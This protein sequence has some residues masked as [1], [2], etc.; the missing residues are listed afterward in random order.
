MTQMR[1]GGGDHYCHAEDGRLR[2]GSPEA[3]AFLLR[4]FILRI[5]REPKR[6]TETA[7]GM[8]SSPLRLCASVVKRSAESQ[9]QSVVKKFR[10]NRY[11]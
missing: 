4:A 1:M 3:G 10:E 2:R 9:L 6:V 5:R 8:L 7:A 11:S